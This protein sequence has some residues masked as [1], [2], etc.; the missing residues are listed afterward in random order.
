MAQC[1]ARKGKMVESSTKR[2]PTTKRLK[3]NRKKEIK[4]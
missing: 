2:K 3:N 1:C 4:I